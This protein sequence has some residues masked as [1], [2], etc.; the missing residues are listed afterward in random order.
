L[1]SHAIE[2]SPEQQEQRDL[3]DGQDEKECDER[4]WRGAFEVL[5]RLDGAERER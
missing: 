5:Q 4:R 2:R 3:A 1:A